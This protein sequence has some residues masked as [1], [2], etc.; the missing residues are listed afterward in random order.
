VSQASDRQVVEHLEAAAEL[1]RQQE[2][3]NPEKKP[4]RIAAYSAAADAIAAY[5]EKYT[6][7]NDLNRL[8]LRYRLGLNL[9]LANRNREAIEQYD[10][11]VEHPLYHSAD[12]VYNSTRIDVS[13]PE[14]L[15]VLRSE[16]FMPKPVGTPSTV[17]VQGNKP[18]SVDVKG[19]RPD[20]GNLSGKVGVSG[21]IQ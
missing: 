10:A 13:V 2:A 5:S 4:Q 21:K 12:A 9:E 15:L 14:R 18:S 19:D 3:V 20:L 6:L 17:E 16:M 8:K 11:C 1:L 7:P